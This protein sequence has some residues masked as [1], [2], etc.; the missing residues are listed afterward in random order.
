[1]WTYVAKRLLYQ[2]VFTGPDAIRESMRSF[3]KNVGPKL[4][5][6]FPRK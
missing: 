2:P 4:E 3:E 1:M 6:S 5:A